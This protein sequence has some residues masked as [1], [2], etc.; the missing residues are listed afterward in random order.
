MPLAVALAGAVPDGLTSL[1][2]SEQGH[3]RN[4]RHGSVAVH[5][6]GSCSAGLATYVLRSL[7]E[8]ARVLLRRD[9]VLLL[10][11]DPVAGIP[12][13]ALA[14]AFRAPLVFQL[15]G[16]VLHPG[17]EYGGR[18]RRF[19]LGLLARRLART[20]AG[21]RCVNAS[22]AA[23]VA[24][25][26][27]RGMVR[28]IGTRVDAQRWHP[29]ADVGDSD[30]VRIAAVGTLT[31]LK[32]YQVLVEAL[33]EL[34]RHGLDVTLDI[35]GEGPTAPA[36]ATCADAHGISDRVRLLGRLDQSTL[37]R[38]LP[39]A[40]LFAH[41][42]LSEG[43]PRAVLEAMAC[44]LPVVVSDI[45]AHREI[46]RPDVSGLLVPA[47]DAHAWAAAI[48][49][50]VEEPGLRAQLAAG[51]RR[52]AVTRFDFERNVRDFSGFLHEAWERA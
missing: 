8:G 12:A 39:S 44:G 33:A 13:M 9:D 42:S 18:L 40:T 43:Q 46:V 27:P 11:S 14:V 49:R 16:E 19:V 50:V 26:K 25:L 21:V 4:A 24:G 32:N 30:S 41:P 20:A 48:R 34:S 36:V 28:V 23:D 22:L 10:A 31:R 17:P 1:V 37:Q 52:E 35:A 6:L 3:R 45:P 2:P 51:A 7:R 47:R 5:Y 15:Q 29:T 38:Q